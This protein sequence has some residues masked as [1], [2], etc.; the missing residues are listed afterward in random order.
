MSAL[1]RAKITD[2]TESRE[3]QEI[4]DK[5]QFL[6]EGTFDKACPEHIDYLQR[7]WD[8]SNLG[9]SDADGTKIDFALQLNRWKDLGFQRDDPI[10]DFRGTGMLGLANLVYFAEQYPSIFLSM[11]RDQQ[12]SSEMEYPFATASINITHLMVNLLGLRKPA[13]WFP[14]M[15]T[16]PLFFFNRKAW[17]ELYTIIFRL[18]DQKWNQ[19]LVGYMGFKKVIDSTRDDVSALLQSKNPMGDDPFIFEMLGILLSDL[20]NFKPDSQRKQELA[21]HAFP[22]RDALVVSSAPDSPKKG[23][24]APVETKPALELIEEPEVANEEE[25]DEEV[26]QKVIEEANSTALD[27][28]KLTEPHLDTVPSPLISPGRSTLNRISFSSLP[29]PGNQWKSS[30]PATRGS[31]RSLL[32]G[33]APKSPTQSKCAT[34]HSGGEPDKSTA[35]DQPTQLDS[36]SETTPLENEL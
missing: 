11:A 34:L 33:S 5:I 12:Q 35:E 32:G 26:P 7:L 2:D 17:E 21:T 14:T 24:E 23:V 4:G 22:A 36:S 28:A 15:D 13:A 30:L 16:Y 29:S 8:A 25:E 9:V 19:M 6:L 1:A 31:N 27:L 3:L 20:E 10:S 18:F